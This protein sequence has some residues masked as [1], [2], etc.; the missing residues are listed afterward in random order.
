[1]K[2]I[3]IGLVVLLILILV[4]AL[5]RWSKSGQQPPFDH[6]GGIG[7]HEVP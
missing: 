3:V 1:M 7:G 2:W 6:T 5:I 4:I